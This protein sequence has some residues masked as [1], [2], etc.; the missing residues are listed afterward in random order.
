[1]KPIKN[2]NEVQAATERQQLPVGGYLVKIMD[3]EVKTYSGRDGGVFE[4]LEIS[5][6]ISDGEHKGYYAQDYRSQ[7][8]E[9]KKWR[10]VLRAYVPKDDGTENDEWT[11]RTFKALTEAVEDSNKGYHWDW[12]E[13]SLKGKVVGCLFRSEEWEFNGHS[14]WAT[15][16]FK[17]VS[18]DVIKENKFRMP[19]EKPLKKKASIDVT[20]DEPQ[21]DFTEITDNDDL[22]F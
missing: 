22:P 7:T 14:G 8:N 4:K 9:D 11:K 18:V 3:A 12:N 20:V 13:S 17:F 15:R 6:D 21:A 10:G 2:W 16:P 5:I 1:M 19:K